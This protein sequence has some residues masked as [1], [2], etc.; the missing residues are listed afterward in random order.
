[1]SQQQAEKISSPAIKTPEE[2]FDGLRADV[3]AAVRNASDLLKYAEAYMRRLAPDDFMESLRKIDESAKILG[4]MKFSGFPENSAIFADLDCLMGNI[5]AIKSKVLQNDIVNVVRTRT[6]PSFHEKFDAMVKLVDGFAVDAKGLNMLTSGLAREVPADMDTITTISQRFNGAPVGFSENLYYSKIIKQVWQR[7]SADEKGDNSHAALAREIERVVRLIQLLSLGVPPNI[8]L[9]PSVHKKTHPIE[10]MGM[11]FGMRNLRYVSAADAEK[12]GEPLVYY[13]LPGTDRTTAYRIERILE[14]PISM[15]SGLNADVLY[16]VQNIVENIPVA[17]T[18]PRFERLRTPETGTDSASTKMTVYRSMD[19]GNTFAK[20]V[21]T[22]GIQ[23]GPDER[24]RLFNIVF[25]SELAKH[26]GTFGKTDAEMLRNAQ[27]KVDDMLK[28]PE[29]VVI[30]GIRKFGHD[31]ADGAPKR[32]GGRY[33]EASEIYEPLLAV[34]AENIRNIKIL[35]STVDAARDSRRIELSLTAFRQLVKGAET[36]SL[37]T[38]N[39][40]DRMP[41]DEKIEVAI[42]KRTDIIEKKLLLG[43]S[44]TSK[45]FAILGYDITTGLEKR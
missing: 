38:Y 19:G 6:S 8:Y 40:P 31:T 22:S 5:T 26:L 12:T 7:S 45:Y 23:N 41:K 44:V 27:N 9:A 3:G 11:Q 24:V 13:H 14:K 20:A 18:T 15:T 33:V 1:M 43:P 16:G 25:N 32:D 35:A 4:G 17:D 28:V 29:D 2:I 10:I 42:R 30:A 37:R 34:S 39:L 21:T 36:I